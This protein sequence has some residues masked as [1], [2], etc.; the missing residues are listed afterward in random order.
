M[1]SLYSHNNVVPLPTLLSWYKIR[2]TFFEHNNVSQNIAL[3][4]EMAA[5][6][7]HPDA[8]WLTE[9]CAGKDVKT[10]EDAKRVFSALGQN[11]ARALCFLWLLG[12]RGD[13]S[14]LRRSAEL[15]FAF[16][17][18]LVADEI[19]GEEKVKFAQL[20]AA[21]GERDGFVW[22]ALC[23]RDGEGCEKDLNKAKENFLLASELGDVW[24]MGWLGHLL[25]ELDRLRWQWWGRASALGDRAN[26]LS[27]FCETSRIVQF[28][29]WKCCC[30]VCTWA[31]ITRTRCGG[32]ENDFQQRIRF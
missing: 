15:G 23:F 29:F 26:F 11:D 24:T 32:C 5:S 8:R 31:S 16:A 14:P 19:S 1:A 10:V 21:Q 9:A 12:D 17:Q 20:A 18:A 30:H 6:C 25:Q 2:D 3:A 27:S 28:W 7:E 22:L 4:L 13:L